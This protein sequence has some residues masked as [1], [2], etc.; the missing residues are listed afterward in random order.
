[1]G[2]GWR[3]KKN[4]ELIHNA[5][6]LRMYHDSYAQSSKNNHAIERTV[7]REAAPFEQRA[8]ASRLEAS[9]SHRGA[10]FRVRP[11]RA[12]G[13]SRRSTFKAQR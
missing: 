5:I 4:R 7:L 13:D 1:M 12:G 2:R 10:Y 6:S 3:K 9:C 8:C 11:P